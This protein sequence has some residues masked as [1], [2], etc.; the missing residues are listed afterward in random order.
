MSCVQFIT[1]STWLT[2]ARLNLNCKFNLSPSLEFSL[3]QFNWMHPE[4]L[5]CKMQFHHVIWLRSVGV[6]QQ[7]SNILTMAWLWGAPKGWF[8]SFPSTT[9]YTTILMTFT[10]SVYTPSSETCVYV[11]VRLHCVFIAPGLSTERTLVW[12]RRGMKEAVSG[13]CRTVSLSGARVERR[14][15]MRTARGKHVF[16]SVLRFLKYDS[17]RPG[18]QDSLMLV[19]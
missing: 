13:L 6:H 5:D 9:T 12:K 2:H 10:A 3:I 4:A 14:E 18:A 7:L 11:S 19:A 1:E 17:F 8:S 16:L 15:E